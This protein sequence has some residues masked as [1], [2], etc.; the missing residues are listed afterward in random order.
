MSLG[1]K[2]CNL[3]VQVLSEHH[4]NLQVENIHLHLTKQLFV[5]QLQEKVIIVVTDEK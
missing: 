4:T 2:T 3:Q 5:A 1:I